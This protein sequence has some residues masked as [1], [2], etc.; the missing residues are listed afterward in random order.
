LF[1]K[2]FYF[3]IWCCQF[4]EQLVRTF[5]FHHYD[6]LKRPTQKSDPRLRQ[7]DVQGGRVV[8]LLFGAFGGDL[9][10]LRRMF[11]A[12]QDMTVTD[13]DGRTALHVAASEGH[14]NCVQF[15]VEKCNVPLM[16]KDRWGGTPLD[17]AVRFGRMS[18]VKY[19]EERYKLTEPCNIM[20]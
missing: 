10:A 17:D 4:C 11:L 15:L 14:L 8:N 18:V 2:F 6:N 1:C 9:T 3:F 13:Y 16:P 7:S 12:N 5:N 20:Q 19:L